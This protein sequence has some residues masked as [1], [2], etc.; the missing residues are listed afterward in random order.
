MFDPN[1]IYTDSTG[2]RFLCEY[3]CKDSNEAEFLEASY[4]GPLRQ[5][6][7]CAE[8]YAKNKVLIIDTP[9]KQTTYDIAI[10][11]NN[12]ISSKN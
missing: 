5:K 6:Y 10:L 8:L 2:V 12:S 1:D 4:L 3:I 9:D 7:F 11:L